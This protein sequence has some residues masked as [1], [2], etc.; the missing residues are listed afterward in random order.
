[1]I[2]EM[3][4]RPPKSLL[5]M[6][7]QLV[8]RHEFSIQMLEADRSFCLY[9]TTKDSSLLPQMYKTSLR[10]KENYENGTC[11]AP[12]RTALM[13]A[14]MMEFKA[15]LAKTSEAQLKSLCQE[16]GW[17]TEDNKWKFLAWSPADKKL[18][19]T[20]K[21]PIM[22]QAPMETVEQI[23]ELTTQQGL[24]HRFHS[25]RPLREN[26]QTETVIMF[27]SGQKQTSCTCCSAD[28][29]TVQQRNS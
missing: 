20:T 6:L 28:F 19:P 8:L 17:L 5:K 18:L 14:M 22:H 3:T 10:W 27:P 24:V 23:I 16:A 7:V 25:L 13:G 21:E 12:L 9:L 2:T 1:M 29:K 26:Y 11:E 15:R 4:D